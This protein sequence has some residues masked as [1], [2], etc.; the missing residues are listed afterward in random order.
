MGSLDWL[1]TVVGIVFFGAVESNPFF[2]QLAT[3]NLLGFT[4]IKLSVAFF[5]GFLFY[6]AYKL[7]NRAENLEG[8]DTKAVRLFLSSAYVA[9]AAFLFFAVLNNVW[10]VAART[11]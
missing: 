10:I 9:S 5:V 4:A 8:K 1:T 7:L 11:A 6:I 3:T 2:S